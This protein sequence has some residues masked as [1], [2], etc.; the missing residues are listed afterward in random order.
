MNNGELGQVKVFAVAFIAM[1]AIAVLWII[2]AIVPNLPA[3][4]WLLLF[5]G[6][7]LLSIWLYL[8]I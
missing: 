1:V 2:G 3:Q 7:G 5:G 8:K 6:V 4:L